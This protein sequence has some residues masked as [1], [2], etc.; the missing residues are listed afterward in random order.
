MKLIIGLGNPGQ[1]YIGTRHNLGRLLVELVAKRMDA[2]AFVVKQRCLS[3]VASATVNDEKVILAQPETFMNS[4]GDAVAKLAASYQAHRN[5]ILILHDE[6]DFDVG[7]FAFC[8]TGGAAGHNGI[9][10]VIASLDTPDFVRLRM[11]IGRSTG[12]VAKDG[13]VLQPFDE[14]EKP[15]VD[16]MLKQAAQAVLDWCDGGIDKSMNLWNGVRGGLNASMD[17]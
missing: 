2:S 11:G 1:E 5:D 6:M 15:L 8:K 9:L 3:R 10:S 16:T 12:T 4:S 7:R 13:Y 17:V 14:T